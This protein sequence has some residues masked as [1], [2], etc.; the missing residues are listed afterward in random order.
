MS[1][2][3]PWVT[4]EALISSPDAPGLGPVGTTTMMAISNTA[5]AI[6]ATAPS[7]SAMD[8]S[9]ATGVCIVATPFRAD[10]IPALD[11]GPWDGWGRAW[12][13]GRSVTDVLRQAPPA[14]GRRAVARVTWRATRERGI[15]IGMEGLDDP[16]PAT[17]R[18]QALL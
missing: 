6:P 1:I 7:R 13:A 3:L 8:R 14:D 2:P 9:C 4:S 17:G 5:A 16:C 15:G 12:F 11:V 10:D 18:A